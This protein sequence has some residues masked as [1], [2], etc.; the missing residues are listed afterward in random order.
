MEYWH[1]DIL[2]GIAMMVGTQIKLDQNSVSGMYGHY[3]R[4]LV[5]VDLSL[6]LQ[7]HVVLERTG[8]YTFVSISYERL[9]DFYSHCSIVGHSITNCKKQPS[10]DDVSDYKRVGVALVM[11]K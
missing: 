8:H 10:K 9:P 4:I 3:I 5:E 7:E 11:E 2:F 6:P 1:P